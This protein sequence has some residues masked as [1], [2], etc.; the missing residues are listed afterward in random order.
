MAGDERTEKPTP[1][2]HKENRRKGVMARSRELPLAV[3]LF[4]AVIALPMAGK[5]LMGNFASSI[6]SAMSAAGSGDPTI[7]MAEARKMIS[8]GVHALALPVL[9]VSGTTMLSTL[10][11]VRQKPNLQ[12]LRP[13]LTGL[14]PK[15]G[16]KRVFSSH[17]LTELVRSL[18]KLVILLLIGY[19]AWRS[20]VSHLISSQTSLDSALH[21]VTGGALS[22]MLKVAL[23]TLLIGVGDAIWARRRFGKQAKMTK[24]EVKDEAKGQ[25]VNPHVK[26]AIRSK[27]MKL[28]RS[29]MMAA[30][31]GAD[32]VLANPTHIA[33]AL[34]YEPG[35]L[36]PVVVAKGAGEV[37]Q[38]IKALAADNDVPVIENKPLARALHAATDVGDI[39]P[40]ELYR[41][42]AEVL[43][44]VFAARRRRGLPAQRTDANPKPR[45]RRR[46]AGG[47]VRDGHSVNAGSNA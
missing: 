16:I 8:Q 44:A 33:V 2:R 28:S 27:Q 14:S 37:A 15:Q 19:A 3:S 31:A 11:V 43:A 20:G 12:M 47:D 17:G 41:A 7:A 30:V 39:I 38:R 29:R 21:A 25:E 18:V 10:L 1:K 32:V 9:L 6:G 42:V 13:R 22:L 46:S 24:Q 4:A 36:A 35:T 23:A 5:N 26:G 34:R 45:P 40:V